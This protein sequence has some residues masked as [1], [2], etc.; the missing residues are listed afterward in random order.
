[1]DTSGA[2]FITTS[3]A[4]WTTATMK[5]IFGLLLAAPRAASLVP[6][7]PRGVDSNC[8][9][10]SNGTYQTI[11]FKAGFDGL[12]I[13]GNAFTH[14]TNAEFSVVVDGDGDGDSALSFTG[15]LSNGTLTATWIYGGMV[16]EMHNLTVLS[17]D[18]NTSTIIDGVESV[19]PKPKWPPK[20]IPLLDQLPS[21]L[22]DILASCHK[23]N[24]PRSLPVKRDQFGVPPKY[25]DTSQVESCVYCIGEAYAASVGC[26]IACGASFGFACACIATIPLIFA[27]C[28]NP[29]TGF[30]TGCCPVGCGPSGS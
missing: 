10:S 15:K 16:Q 5:R 3:A 26:G 2:L 23:P 25:D 11:T 4:P 22:K 30:G 14:G 29:G 20:L 8:V 12:T 6:L 19:P 21:V 1:L 24:A 17:E 18:N 13:Q 28:H 27:N 9:L 7:V